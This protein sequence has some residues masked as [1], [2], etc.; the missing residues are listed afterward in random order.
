LTVCDD[1]Q[2]SGESIRIRKDRFA[3]GRTEGDLVIPHDSRMSGRHAELRQSQAGEKYRWT[4]VDLQS[5]NGTYVRVGQ[6]VLHHGQ[7]FL[8]GSARYRFESQASADSAAADADGA[9]EQRTRLWQAPAREPNSAALVE[10]TST[11]DGSRHLLEGGENWLG[12]DA[13][14]CRIVLSKDPLVSARHA[15]IRRRDDGRWL[16]ENNNSVNGVW[17]RV[18][19]I[20]FKGTCR[21][22]LG[23]QKFTIKT[24]E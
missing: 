2:E 24:P 23:E 10:L 9:G 19:Q 14:R 13:A 21:F 7:E 3:I 12:K 5:S 1:G 17:M 16:L 20:S 6:A 15:R 18:E 11:G 4:L 8:L 22:L